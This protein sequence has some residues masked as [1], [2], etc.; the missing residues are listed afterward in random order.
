MAPSMVRVHE[1]ADGVSAF[2]FCKAARRGAD[3]SLESIG[4][5]HGPGSDG[6]FGHRAAG[7]AIERLRDILFRDM[8]ALYII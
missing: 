5:H 2:P 8:P 3:P 6:T 7:G 4:H 1:H